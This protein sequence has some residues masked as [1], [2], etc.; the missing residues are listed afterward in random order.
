[1]FFTIQTSFNK[2][3][4]IVR[5]FVWCSRDPEITHVTCDTVDP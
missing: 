1:M 2:F 4:S 3:T 5:N